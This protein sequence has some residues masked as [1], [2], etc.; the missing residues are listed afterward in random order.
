MVFDGPSAAT[1]SVRASSSTNI[2]EFELDDSEQ[3]L[4]SDRP[5]RREF[6]RVVSLYVSIVSPG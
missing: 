1:T 5:G 2:E 3:G 6:R 4:L